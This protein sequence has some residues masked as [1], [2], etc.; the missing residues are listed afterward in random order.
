MANCASVDHTLHTLTPLHRK[1]IQVMQ[2]IISTSFPQ[3]HKRNTTSHP[4]LFI[5]TRNSPHEKCSRHT[6]S[7]CVRTPVRI[8]KSNQQLPI[9]SKVASALTQNGMK[10]RHDLFDYQ[11]NSTSKCAILNTAAIKLHTNGQSR[12]KQFCEG[13]TMFKLK[14]VIRLLPS[15]LLLDGKM[16]D[17][18]RHVD[19]LVKH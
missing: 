17:G 7:H 4:M 15:C 13:V 6:C 1:T 11:H 12:L 5:N 8:R 10:L 18:S 9:G 14:Y 3:F 19:V 2:C 16:A